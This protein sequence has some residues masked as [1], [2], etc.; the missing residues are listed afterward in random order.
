MDRI[1]LTVDTDLSVDEILQ[2]LTANQIVDYYRNNNLLYLLLLEVDSATMIAHLVG[3]VGDE[4]Q[5]EVSA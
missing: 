4:G 1:Y 3:R 2:H 5:K